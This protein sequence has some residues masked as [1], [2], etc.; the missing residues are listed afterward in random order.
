MEYKRAAAKGTKRA[1]ESLFLRLLR[2]F[3][4]MIVFES[5][6]IPD[7]LSVPSVPSPAQS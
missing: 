1:E 5:L 3:A 7:A 2:F 6:W 4:A